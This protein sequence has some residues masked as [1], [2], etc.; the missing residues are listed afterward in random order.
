MRD[1]IINLQKSDASIIHLTI[2]INFISSKDVNEKRVMHSKSDSIE[3]MPYDNANE[4][5]NEL[6]ES[7]LSRYQKSISERE[8]DFIFDSVQLLHRCH[9]INFKRED[10]LLVLLSRLDKKQN[11]NKS[12]KY[13]L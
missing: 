12:E 1:I 13:R 6:F 8:S 9:N 4:V 3:I 2:E 10:H 5:V 11:K 7:L